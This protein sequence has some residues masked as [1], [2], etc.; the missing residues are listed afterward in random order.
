MEFLLIP[1]TA[2]A[3]IIVAS[4][5]AR[6]TGVAAPLIL[7][8]LGICVSFLP[9]MPSVALA[10]RFTPMA[11]ATNRT[12]QPVSE[13]GARERMVELQRRYLDAMREALVEEQSIGAFR[14]ETYARIQ[15]MLDRQE[16]TM[17]LF[18]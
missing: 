5:F 12:E 2:L 7:L 4:L 14:T 1:L 9:G 11:N 13:S 18:T 15:L 8:V 6:R 16:T 3:V 17:D 10:G